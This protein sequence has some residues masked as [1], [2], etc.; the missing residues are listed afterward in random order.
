MKHLFKWSDE[1]RNLKNTNKAAILEAKYQNATQLKEIELLN[2][3][4]AINDRVRLQY[5][6]GIF[7]LSF[8]LFIAIV[9]FI[10]NR[11]NLRKLALVNK[12]LEKTQGELNNRNSE[13][14]KYIESNIQLEQFAHIASH[15]LRAPIITINSFSKLLDR[16]AKE[17]LTPKEQ[18]YLNFINSNGTQ[19]YELV[20]D[21][22]EYSKINS[23]KI[24]ITKINANAVVRGVIQTLKSQA[25]DKD[26]R[27]EISGEL[28]MVIFADEIKL[29]RVFQNLISNSIK[30]AA[31]TR[32]SFVRIE[33]VEL[34]DFWQ[35]VVIDNGI[36]MKPTKV[37]IFQPYTQLN[38]KSDFKGTG[39]GLSFCQ[40]IIEQHGGKI[41]FK[42][43]FREGTQ[44]FFTIAKLLENQANEVKEIETTPQQT[45]LI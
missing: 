26:V 3:E 34:P 36:G 11:L 25:E 23:Q 7:I 4:K 2:K 9:L 41:T 12:K 5:T 24:N 15:D 17:R 10:Y 21:L 6:A 42:S 1:E 27:I 39:M 20:N 19:I 28:P 31:Q 35:F 8:S 43:R 30:F 45:T 22:L 44:F 40:K 32:P 29:K 13:L 37:D 38:R 16:S 14:E 33:C 18:E